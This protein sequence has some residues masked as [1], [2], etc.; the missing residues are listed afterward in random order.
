[1]ALEAVILQIG[2]PRRRKDNYEFERDLKL[3]IGE[4]FYAHVTMAKAAKDAKG[5][6]AALAH[7]RWRKF[8]LQGK[9]K[10]GRH[11][12]P[13]DW[14]KRLRRERKIIWWA[15]V[16]DVSRKELLRAG[17]WLLRCVADADIVILTDKGLLPARRF[18][19]DLRHLHRLI[20]RA[21]VRLLPLPH[22][23]DRWTGPEIYRSGLRV[24]FL[25]HYNKAHQAS[26]TASFES[27]RF[28]KH[29]LAA[30][31]R[32]GDI[33][34]CVDRWT[35]DLVDLYA[36]RVRNYKDAHRKFAYGQQVDRVV[37]ESARLLRRGV[38]WN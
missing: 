4:I 7:L 8:T 34:L 21:N 13:G 11:E 18:G 17:S 36:V 9:L 33:P 35:L 12:S 37:T 30:V 31:N 5:D 24:K 16:K 2:R 14:L 1:M 38:F 22:K 20:V 6:K 23:P 10:V 25:P 29:H 19:Q 28:Q 27:E 3:A 15:L 26:I 32:L